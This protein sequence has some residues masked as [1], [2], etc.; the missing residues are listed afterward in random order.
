MGCAP[1]PLSL[2]ISGRAPRQSGPPAEAQTGAGAASV[3]SDV[4]RGLCVF[5]AQFSSASAGWTRT[6][7]CSSAR[8]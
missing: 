1:D 2:P 6:S 4:R 8:E 3:A 5:A 7:C